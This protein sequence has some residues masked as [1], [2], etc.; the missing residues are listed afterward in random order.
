MSTKKQGGNRKAPAAPALSAFEKA[1]TAAGLT[2]APGKSAVENR[3]RG[4]VE[5]KTADTRFTGSLDMDAAFKQVEPEA[6]RWDFGI[7]MRK[8][9]KQEFAVWVEPHSASSLGEVK[10]I[11]AK[12]DWLQGKLDQPE[13]RQLKAL[14][15]ACAAQGHR[16]FHWMATARVGIRPGSREANMLAARGMNPPSTRVVI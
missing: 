7:G 11:L 2:A 10:T 6:N 16:R 9:G 13:F 5:G 3:Y 12:L 1:A 4:S 14:T 15:D 8:P